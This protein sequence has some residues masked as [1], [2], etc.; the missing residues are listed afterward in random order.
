[1]HFHLATIRQSSYIIYNT[2]SWQPSKHKE[3]T[4]VLEDL[5]KNHAIK[6]IAGFKSS[7]FI[8]CSSIKLY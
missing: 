7:R 1:V 6:R 3:N 5:K 8:Y 4:A 2:G